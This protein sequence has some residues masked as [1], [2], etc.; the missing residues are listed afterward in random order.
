[1]DEGLRPN[2]PGLGVNLNIWFISLGLYQACIQSHSCK[3][4]NAMSAHGAETLVVEEKHAYRSVF[5]CGVGEDSGIHISMTSRF[6]DD[7]LSKMV[8]I[9]L[10][11][12]AFF[13]DCGAWNLGDTTCDDPQ[14]RSSCVG[15]Y[16]LY[17]GP[18]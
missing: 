8:E 15:V 17:H 10:G 3:T 13:Q 14:R 2:P 1:M 5:G 9:I 11:I 6:P 12:P 18:F 4:N 7:G 16:G